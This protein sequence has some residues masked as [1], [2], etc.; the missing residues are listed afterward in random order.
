M[1]NSPRMA[2]LITCDTCG[3]E[4]SHVHILFSD[5]TKSDPFTYPEA[6]IAGIEKAVVVGKM[7]HTEATPLLDEVEQ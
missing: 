5:D 1:N 2:Q 3:E 4:G 7:T 6:I